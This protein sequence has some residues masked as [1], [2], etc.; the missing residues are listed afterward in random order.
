MTSIPS[1][2]SSTRYAL[3]IWI[4]L[5]TSDD[6][7]ADKTGAPG[8]V[9]GEPG[10][11]SPPGDRLLSEPRDSP[12]ATLSPAAGS[13]AAGPPGCCP[14]LCLP[15]LCTA[16]SRPGTRVKVGKPGWLNNEGDCGGNG[17]GAS[18]FCVEPTA[19]GVAEARSRAVRFSA[20]R[21]L[22]TVAF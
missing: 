6:S 1:G 10:G 17:C 8:G 4:A 5:N 9:R 19:K 11:V 3:C 20:R 18:Q 7:P 22:R 14:L 15:P 13:A 21:R 16:L 2:V 12:S